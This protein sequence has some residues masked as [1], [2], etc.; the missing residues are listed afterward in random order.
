MKEFEQVHIF[1]DKASGQSKGEATISYEDPHTVRYRAAR[2]GAARRGTVRMHAWMQ[3]HAWL[4]YCR[5]S[6]MSLSNAPPL[7]CLS[8]CPVFRFRAS[9]PACTCMR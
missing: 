5:F 6:S 3:T 1:R 9:C 8:A 7:G 4:V 2:H